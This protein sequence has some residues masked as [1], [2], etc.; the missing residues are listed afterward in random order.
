MIKELVNKY[1]L[2]KE[3]RFLKKHNCNSW[4]QFDK[5]YDIDINRHADRIKDYYLGYP[6]IYIFK[7]TTKEIFNKH[8][9]WIDGYK[10][11]ESWCGKH[12][13]GKYRSDIHRVW[14]QTSIDFDGNTETEYHFND[15]GGHDFL[16]FAFKH[17]FDYI[18]FTTRWS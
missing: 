9:D 15:I 14:P 6:Y 5:V 17:E 10:E 1:K 13:I 11:L 7:D 2:Y 12:C 8:R 16:F 3:Q 4:E 18:W